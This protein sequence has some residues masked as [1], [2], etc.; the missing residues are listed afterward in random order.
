[1]YTTLRCRPIDRLG[2]DRA[3]MMSPPG[4]AYPVLPDPAL[5]LSTRLGRDYYV[6]SGPAT[7][8]PKAVGR[9]VDIRVD[10]E[11]LTISSASELVGRH[12][13]SWARHR[14]VTDPDHDRARKAQ[15]AARAGD[16]PWAGPTTRSRCPTCPCM[17]KR[18]PDDHRHQDQAGR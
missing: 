6:R 2:E 9:P 18:P 12:P 1:M 14:V 5:R 4:A 11:E 17:T 16:S 7:T 15:R 3:A 8:H 13:R 10:L